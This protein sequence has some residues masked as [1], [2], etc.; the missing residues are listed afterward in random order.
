[1]TISSRLEKEGRELLG[2]SKALELEGLG[3]DSFS[4]PPFQSVGQLFSCALQEL[5]YLN[6]LYHQLLF[7]QIAREPVKQDREPFGADFWETWLERF[8]QHRMA[9]GPASPA[10]SQ[11]DRTKVDELIQVLEIDQLLQGTGEELTDRRRVDRLSRSHTESK[12][13]AK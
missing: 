11:F 6:D 12:V 4:H 13:H 7:D 3:L 5:I 1:M 8:K 9:P 2:A 10:P